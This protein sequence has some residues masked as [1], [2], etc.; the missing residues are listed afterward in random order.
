M[1]LNQMTSTQS[2]ILNIQ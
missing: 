2:A 1:S